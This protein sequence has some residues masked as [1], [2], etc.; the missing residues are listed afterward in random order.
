[1]ERLTA[2]LFMR[3]RR[4]N[5]PY[6]SGIVLAFACLLAAGAA[7]HAAPAP[8]IAPAVREAV[9][10]Q[11]FADVT[12]LFDVPALR[13]RASP[14]RRGSPAMAARIATVRDRL[15]GRLGA[16]GLE[17]RRTFTH[18]E[19]I[20]A[21]VDAATL[22]RLAA[23]P[24][25]ASVGPD[26]AGH[27]HLVE[28][29]PLATLDGVQALGLR[30]AG[31][32]VAVLD[33]GLD[34]DHPDLADDLVAEACFC[35]SPGGAACCPIGDPTQIG[36]GSAE[37]DNGHGTN[38]TGIVT[39]AGGI[40]PVGGAPD[41]GIVAVKVLD[42][43]NNFGFLSDVVA[44]LDWVIQNRP[45]VDLVNMSLG[46]S[47]L[48]DAGK[49]DGPM[50]ATPAMTSAIDTLRANGVLVFASAGNEASG[51]RMPSPACSSNAISVG[52][53]Y[54]S[55]QGARSYTACSD[56]TTA[57]DQVTCFSNSNATTDLFAPGAATQ[58][59][60]LLG[61][62]SIYTGTSQASPLAAACA[63]L[64]LEH[65]PSFTPDEIESLLE[66]SPTLVTDATNG[67]SFPRLDCAHALAIGT[68]VPLLAP[69]ATL[70]LA[71]GFPITFTLTT[72]ARRRA[73]QRRSSAGGRGAGGGMPF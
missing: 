6:T 23:D 47:A 20:A 10:R 63:A 27:G 9:A 46:T 57:A 59:T 29:V 67:L 36:A 21:R 8:R 1:M 50:A 11:G 39:G 44:G 31:V 5:A 61:W 26:V 15:L 66:A 65:D 22:A 13:D 30:G 3:Q 12:I 45:D 49:C 51:T 33:S 7:A 69:F 32:T 55:D 2:E 43:A 28:A 4:S 34:T 48:F 19:A 60:G 14:L 37:D 38:V 72:A 64:L 68:P 17:V 42:A 16:P 56:P 25:V 70:A 41:A 54:D 58:S 24:D 52:A 62:Q 73:M 35:R 40:A 53:V 71:L 18:V